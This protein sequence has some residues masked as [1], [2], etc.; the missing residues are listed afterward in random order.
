MAGTG[1]AESLFR[2]SL[3]HHCASVPPAIAAGMFMQAFVPCLW[4]S[5]AGGPCIFGKGCREKWADFMRVFRRA[6]EQLLV[7]Y[8]VCEQYGQ[9]VEREP[10][11][12]QREQ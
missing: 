9:R 12:R 8:Y 10:Q 7:E 6:V 5:A 4:G 1:K 3:F 2:V 11:Q